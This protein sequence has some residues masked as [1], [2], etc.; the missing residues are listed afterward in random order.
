[1]IGAITG[2]RKVKTALALVLTFC[3]LLGNV[4]TS[5]NQIVVNAEESVD[6][7]ITVSIT[8]RDNTSTAETGERLTATVYSTYSK[9]NND[10][11]DQ[12][13]YIHISELPDGVSIVGF[14]NNQM[15]IAYGDNNENTL[16]AYLVACENG[17]Y[18]IYFTQPAGSTI[19]FDIMFDSTNGTMP[20]SSYVELTVEKI[21]D[22]DTEEEST[23][24][25]DDISADCTLTWTA[26]NEWDAVDKKVNYADSNTIVLGSDGTLSGDLVYTITAASSNNDSYGEI[27]TEYIEVTDTLTLPEGITFPDGMTLNAAGTAF[28]DA[29]G[30]EVLTLTDIQG[31]TVESYSIS[32]DG[33]TLTYTLKVPNSYMDNGVPTKEMDN[34]SL[35]ITLHASTLVVADSIKS[36]TEAALA[37]KTITNAVT[38]QPVPYQTYDVPATSDS[39][40]TTL[41]PQSEEFTFTKTANKTSVKAGDTITYT[42]TITNTGSVA[43]AAVD[44]NGDYYTVTDTLPSYL[45]LTDAQ[46]SAAKNYGI[47]YD[48]ATNTLTWTPSTTSIAAGAT[49]SVSFEVTVQSGTDSAMSSLYSGAT[50][51]N[52]A[53]Y[54]DK[55]ASASVEYKR[56]VVTVVKTNSDADNTVT[57]GDIISYTIT[58]ANTSEIDTYTNEVLTDML[59]SALEFTSLDSISLT[60]D[61]STYTTADGT[62]TDNGDG[63]YSF[64]CSACGKAH[65]I[66]FTQSGQ[67]LTWDLGIL[68]AGETVTIAY[69]CTVDTD[70]LGDSTSSITNSVS[71]TSGESDGDT[72][73]VDYPLDID[74]E[75]TSTGSTY[76]DGDTIS[77][78]ITVSND[79][80]HPSTEATITV[81]DVLDAGLIP[82]YTLYNASGKEVTWD[83]FLESDRYGSGYYTIINGDTVTV[84]GSWDYKITLTWTIA[85]P[86]AGES[87]VLTYDVTLNVQSGV[88]KYTNTAK[89]KDQSSEVTITG[90]SDED[91]GGYIDLQKS[92]YAIAEDTG[93]WSYTGLNSK[94]AFTKDLAGSGY[95]VYAITIINT[96]SEDVSLDIL[97]D[98]LPDELS[99]VGIYGYSYNTLAKD[100]YSNSTVT[101]GNSNNVVDYSGTQVSV[102]LT[103]VYDASSNLVTI[104][105]GD[106]TGCSLAGG[107]SISFLMM[108]KITSATNDKPITNTASLYVDEDVTYKDYEEIETIKTPYDAN[109]NNGSSQDEGTENGERIISSSVTITPEEVIVPG[110]AKT[111]VSYIPT[112]ST[113]ETALTDDSVII[114]QAAVKWE[115][116]LYNGGTTDLSGYTVEDTVTA[117]YAHLITEDEA[118]TKGITSAYVITIYNSSG[119][120]TVTYDISSEV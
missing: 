98:Q 9:A 7:R 75:V 104:T 13:I 40:I 55:S 93:E 100:S 71:G 58:A 12:T 14:T 99:Y 20:A 49:A 117:S 69:T 85:T 80:D 6:N 27:W 86:A 10:E 82:N 61:G 36:L 116:T 59:P 96:G 67:T 77:Y 84:S 8:G 31:A 26:T 28:I 107:C 66:T 39:V 18:D 76:A 17:G 57:N 108:C 110:I 63:T 4:L 33:T 5:W 32:S 53:S 25:N 83:Y 16:I 81:T 41:V 23:A 1:M 118:A 68:H 90:G 60:V 51:T 105:I 87:V 22:S 115:I 72:V 103:A 42:L 95:V 65:T 30:N 64:T 29:G 52:S 15:T 2:N 44:E 56:A 101:A 35:K 24:S 119:T 43:I 37:E 114:P 38:I 70:E 79:A 19:E 3:V 78:S 45:Y 120:A 102:N 112:A 11:G 21:V 48:S 54:K 97:E 89:L 47:I 46:I 109:Q 62:L 113:T 34:L 74:K 111:A 92:V 106:G 73:N 50:I 94:E 88:T 91:T